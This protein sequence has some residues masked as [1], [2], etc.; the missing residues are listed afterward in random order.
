MLIHYIRHILQGGISTCR[1][2]LMEKRRA[3]IP[4][5]LHGY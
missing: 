2:R 4:I 3:G 5:L 1:Y